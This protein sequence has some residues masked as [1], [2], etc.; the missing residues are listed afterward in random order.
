MMFYNT[1]FTSPHPV[2]VVTLFTSL[3][4]VVPF[5]TNTDWQHSKRH[6]LDCPFIYWI[7]KQDC[8]LQPWISAYSSVANYATTCT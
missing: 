4:T 8:V 5:T 7:F 6:F 3:D 1:D 2:L